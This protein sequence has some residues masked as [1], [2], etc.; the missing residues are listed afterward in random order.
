M[1]TASTPAAISWSIMISVVSESTAASTVPST[2]MS[3]ATV[4]PVP[5]FSMFGS[6]RRLPSASRPA[7]LIAIDRS[8]PQSSSRTM[9][10]CATSTS[11]RVRY[12]ESAV[13][14]AVSARPLRAPWVEMKYSRTDSPSRKLDLIG[15]GMISPR[16]LATRPRMPAIWRTCMMFPRAPEPT[17]M[18]MGLKTI[19]PRVFSMA[20]RTSSVALVQISTSFWRRSSSVMMPFLNCDSIFSASFS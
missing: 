9:T 15:R 17:I 6:R 7:I 11:R 20:R 19:E 8:V 14:R 13:R 12:P 16:G 1:R 5:V 18:S 3:S 10:S 4:R 2:S